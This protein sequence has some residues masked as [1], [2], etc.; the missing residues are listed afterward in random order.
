MKPVNLLNAVV[1]SSGYTL[2]SGIVYGEDERQKL[3]IYYPAAPV[4]G[5][6]VIAFIYGGAWR[7][8]NRAE[9]E[10]VGQALAEAGHT[11]IIPDYRLYPSVVFPDFV[12]DVADAILAARLPLEMRSGDVVDE[13]VLMGHSSGAHTAALLAGDVSW[14]EKRGFRA[15]ALVA[16]SGP[17]DLPLEDPEVKPVFAG[18]QSEEQVIPVAL[19]TSEHPPTLLIHGR[20]DERVLPFHTQHYADA[21]QRAGVRVEVQWL[22]DTGHAFAIAGLAAPLD[23]SNRNRDRI[24]S[25]L[26]LL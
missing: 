2:Q 6:R 14:L 19:V 12:D 13:V 23:S 1:P 15:S 7:E 20:K 8:G 9:Y 10:F 18:V 11:V 21:L 22:E 25:F 17:Y 16:I 26:D 3:D 24:T 4:P 5:S